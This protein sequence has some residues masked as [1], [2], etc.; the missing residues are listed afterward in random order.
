MSWQAIC[1]HFHLFRSLLIS[2]HR[3]EYFYPGFEIFSLISFKLL[4]HI[5]F[6]CTLHLK[7]TIPSG[8]VFVDNKSNYSYYCAMKNTIILE[9]TLRIRSAFIASFGRTIARK[10]DIILNISSIARFRR[11]CNRNKQKEEKTTRQLTLIHKNPADTHIAHNF[12]N[13]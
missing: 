12:I 8:F 7:V 10:R 1:H 6:D 3:F 4:I 5:R 13:L 9:I 11:C 2:Q